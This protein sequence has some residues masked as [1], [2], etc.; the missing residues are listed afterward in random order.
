MAKDMLLYNRPLDDIYPI[1]Y[2]DA[3]RIKVKHNGQIITKVV[4]LAILVGCSNP[5][6]KRKESR[7]E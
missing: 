6:L 5:N 2:L 7:D 4:Y 3:I 1:V